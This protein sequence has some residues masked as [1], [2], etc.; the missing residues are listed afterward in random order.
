[1][2]GLGLALVGQHLVAHRLD[3]RAGAGLLGLG[4]AL[5]TLACWPASGGCEGAATAHDSDRSPSPG[6]L[7]RLWRFSTPVALNGFALVLFWRGVQPSLAWIAWA[8]SLVAA[9][10]VAWSLAGRPRPALWPTREL[11]AVL[12]LTAL[13]AAFRLYRLDELPP[14]LWWDEAVG[15]LEALKILRQPDY[16]P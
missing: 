4:A 1:M 5:F 8:A 7:A 15:G 16:R 9:G 13:G 6:G 11:A 14:G 10:S 12:V 2:A 3:L